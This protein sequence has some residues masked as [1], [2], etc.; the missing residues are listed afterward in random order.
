MPGLKVELGLM[1]KR[2]F[3]TCLC[4]FKSVILHALLNRLIILCILM[5]GM[6]SCS[7]YSKLLKSKNYEAKY[8]AVNSLYTAGKCSKAIPLLD[9]LR[10]HYRYKD[11]IAFLL[12]LSGKCYYET[13]EYDYAQL[14]FKDYVDNFPSGQYVEEC[15][16]KNLECL[17]KTRYIYELDQSETIK[18]VDQI[19][20]YVNMYPN[21][22]YLPQCN[23]ML[24][25]LRKGLRLKEVSKTKQYFAVGDY[26]AA[27]VAAQNTIQ[28]YP[29]LENLEELEHMMVVAQFNYAEN[30]IRSKKSERF[31]EVQELGNDY[32]RNHNDKNKTHYNE[33]MALLEKTN[34]G[35]LNLKVNKF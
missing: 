29:S 10:E 15:A 20:I 24:D 19:K 5:M 28:A 18:T 25:E 11:T 23:D 21:S 2:Y 30:S 16:Y 22:P 6:L 9:Q 1:N 3:T 26:R 17:Y 32:L 8:F 34:K 14:F 7:D 33:V 31:E 35:L 12:Q 13:S 27:V 4:R